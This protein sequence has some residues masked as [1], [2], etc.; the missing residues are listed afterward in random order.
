MQ[1]KKIRI[2]IFTLVFLSLGACSINQTEKIPSTLTSEATSTRST[3]GTFAGTSWPFLNP[4]AMV[5]KTIQHMTLDQK[6]GQM[7]MV[8]F[9]DA[10]YDNYLDEM[11]RV[12]HPG[13]L[14][15]Y[16]NDQRTIATMQKLTADAQ[17]HADFPLMIAL[18]QE[19]GEVNRLGPFYGDAPSA[20]SIAATGDPTNAYSQGVRDA[21][22][23]LGLGFNTNLAPVVDVRTTSSPV[24]GTRLWA[25]TAAKT[26]QF[27]GAYL[28]GN[29][30]QG[31]IGC[32]KHWPGIG[33]VTGDPHTSLPVVPDT[34]DE[35]NQ[36][37]FTAFKGLFALGPAMIMT[38]HVTIPAL[39]S[40]VPTTL[41]SQMVT[42]I[43]R[44]QMGYQGVI[45]TDSLHMEGIYQYIRSI[46]ITGWP[47]MIG[48]AAVQAILAG[49]DILEGA[50]DYYSAKGM[51]DAIRVAI[52]NGR[53]PLSRI[54]ASDRR[55]LRLKWGYN[56]GVDRLQVAANGSSAL[57]NGLSLTGIEKIA[58]LPLQTRSQRR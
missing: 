23:M 22:L 49:N 48:E 25:D 27:A 56:I 32:L 14:L 2:G 37:D 30:S 42:D 11:M 1:L 52:T 35:L 44:N 4:D 17:Q 38:T 40:T 3:S 20:A 13:G 26:D 57:N 36:V 33:A 15:I 24:E 28:Q 8:E 5:E 10:S 47:D 18:D 39:D 7:F 55:I 54:E 6:I 31:V 34:L 29:Q 53:I 16:N 43:L 45:I 50:F 46:G 51:M 9:L 12:A 41:S 58:L 21:K 19:G